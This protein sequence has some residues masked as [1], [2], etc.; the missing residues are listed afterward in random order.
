MGFLR[1]AMDL[2]AA[3]THVTQRSDR[4]HTQRT[5]F[6]VYK[7]TEMTILSVRIPPSYKQK[8]SDYFTKRHTSLSTGVRFMI[9]DFI[10]A[11]G[12]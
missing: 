1:K 5:R 6:K 11:N 9:G 10:E 4:E 2:K 7:P 8:L 12:L 3:Y